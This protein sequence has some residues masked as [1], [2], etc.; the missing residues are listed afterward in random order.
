MTTQPGAY[1]QPPQQEQ[2]TTAKA[3]K[4]RRR[5]PWVLGTIVA[6]GVGATAGSGGLATQ[7]ST[8]AAQPAPATR[9]VTASPAAPAVQTVTAPPVTQTVTVTNQ[10]PAAPAPVQAPAGPLTSFGD[11]TYKV[12]TDIATGSY[13]TSGPRDSGIECYWARLKDDSG[14]NIIANDLT[15]GATRFTTKSGEYV[16]IT[17]CDFTKS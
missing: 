13:K 16:Q 8:L 15:A 1:E 4:K 10:P 5:W 7:N 14:G 17:G 11:G 9:T 2:P 3:V 12:G 6:F